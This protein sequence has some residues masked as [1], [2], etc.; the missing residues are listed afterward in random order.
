M[1]TCRPQSA[2]VQKHICRFQIACLVI[3]IAIGLPVAAAAQEDKPTPA[4]SR[5]EMV[6]ESMPRTQRISQAE[7]SPDGKRV[8]WITRNGIFILPLDEVG[9]TAT[10]KPVKLAEDLPVL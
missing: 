5:A 10:L 3:S 7:I 2:L 6:L 9:K 1:Y 8:A 4:S